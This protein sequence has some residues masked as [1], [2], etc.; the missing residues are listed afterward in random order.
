MKATSTRRRSNSGRRLYWGSTR[1]RS[2]QVG[3]YNYTVRNTGQT[4]VGGFP[5]A[6]RD[7]GQTREGVYT[8]TVAV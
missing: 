3:G 2:I 5:G 7:K 1:Q 6:V 8:G 4:Q